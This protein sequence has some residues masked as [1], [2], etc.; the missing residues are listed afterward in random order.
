MKTI[1]LWSGRLRVSKS[2]TIEGVEAISSQREARAK[3]HW[4]IQNPRTNGEVAY[5]LE[6]PLQLSTVHDMFHVSQLKKCLW[7][8][9]EQGPPED[10]LTGEDLAYQEYRIKVLETSERVMRNKTIRIC[11]VQWSHH[12]EEEAM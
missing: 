10:L 6:L 7:V 5:W 12:I 9:E 4:A 2:I 1:K 8:I 11:K 3:V